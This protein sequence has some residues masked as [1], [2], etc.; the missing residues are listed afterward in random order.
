LLLLVIGSITLVMTYIQSGDKP[1]IA[2]LMVAYEFLL[3]VSA[4]GFGLGSGVPG[5]WPEAGLVFVIHLAI[6]LVISLILFFYM[7]FHP[8]R[9]GGYFMLTALCL[10]GV[11][12]LVGWAG[13]GNL[14]NIRGDQ[15]NALV[16]ITPTSSPARPTALRPNPTFTRVPV[17]SATPSITPLPRLEPSPSAQP[18]P[19]EITPTASPAVISEPTLLPTPVYGRVQ[20]ES[21]GVMVRKEPGGTSITTVQNGYLVEI[22]GD[23]PVVVDGTVWVHVIVRT[24]IRDIEGWVLLDLIVTA[25]PSSP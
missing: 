4:A 7:G 17:S 6:S 20:S 23:A 14:I 13:F 2:S 9:I 10:G 24:P 19:T 5:L 21:G 12:V 15:I 16:T 1:V 25:T 18:S 3:P 22:I 11:A 8:E